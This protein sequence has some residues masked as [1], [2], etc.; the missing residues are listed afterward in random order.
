MEP[1]ISE[2]YKEL[3]ALRQENSTLNKKVDSLA[4]ANA[5]AAELLAALEE[6]NE[7]EEK[8]VRQGEEL[9]L[10]AKIDVVLKYEK[11]ETRVLQRIIA[12]FKE[13]PALRIQDLEVHPPPLQ[14]VGSQ[15]RSASG[16]RTEAHAR[17]SIAALKQTSRLK[18]ENHQVHLPIPVQ[19]NSQG[20]ILLTV[21]SC[22]AFGAIVGCDS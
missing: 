17:D 8:L 4:N 1:S 12:I 13:T 5:Y 15:N 18:V 9:D 6:A 20:T 14:P 19:E 21:R 22:D 10:Q 11:T 3:D 7:R 2:L 16:D